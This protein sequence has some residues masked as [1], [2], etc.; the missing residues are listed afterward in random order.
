[1]AS[2]DRDDDKAPAKPSAKAKAKDDVKAPTFPE[3][4][5]HAAPG[6]IKQ[7]EAIFEG[8]GRGREKK[9]FVAGALKALAR[10][11]NWKEIPDIIEHPLEDALVDALV[12]LAFVFVPGL[13]KPEKQA[14]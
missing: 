5:V 13:K 6:L 2:A 8:P 3:I 11:H 10:A 7:A 9:A 14:A 4:L 1:M 12:E